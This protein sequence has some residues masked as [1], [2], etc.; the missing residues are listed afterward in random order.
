MSL[1]DKVKSLW[2]KAKQFF[3][4]PRIINSVG[5]HPIFTSMIKETHD[6]QVDNEEYS[7]GEPVQ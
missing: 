5:F 2:F 3:W 6:S 7:G 4:R 1:L